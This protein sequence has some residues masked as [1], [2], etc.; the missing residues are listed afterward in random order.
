MVIMISAGWASHTAY[1]TMFCSSLCSKS[2]QEKEAETKKAEAEA[3]D[4]QRA[5]DQMD[6]S[7]QKA[8][9]ENQQIQSRMVRY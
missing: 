7:I 8:T 5:L 4:I 6:V 2:L 9:Q 1:F 3:R